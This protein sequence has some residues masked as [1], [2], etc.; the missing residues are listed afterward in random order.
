MLVRAMTI[1]SLLMYDTTFMVYWAAL[2]WIYPF[3]F[4]YLERVCD[5]L[6]MHA[7]MQAP[8]SFKVGSSRG[9]SWDQHG[10]VDGVKTTSQE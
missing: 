6:Q 9:S 5:I 10:M 3:L 1:L 8:E 2:V 7:S 4:D